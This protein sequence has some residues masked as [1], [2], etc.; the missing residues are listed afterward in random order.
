MLLQTLLSIVALFL[1]LILLVMGNNLLGTVIAL[2][3]E[4]EGYRAG[5]AGTVLAFFSIGFVLGSLLG[6]HVIRRVGHIRAFAV[7]GA[8]AG[9]AALL[10]SIHISVIGWGGLRLVLGFCIA[11]LMLITES[12]ANTRATTET[13]GKLLATYMVLF[14]LAASLGQFLIGWGDPATHH[15]FI[16]AAILIV[17]SLIPLSLTRSPAPELE[18][19]ERLGILELWRKSALGVAGALFSAIALSAFAAIG[20]IFAVRSGL[21]VGQV[22]AFMGL[23]ILAAML[24]Q[25]PIGLLSDYVPRRILILVVIGGSIAAG[26]VAAW[27]GDQSIL[28]LY[29]SVSLFYGLVACIYPLCLAL[30]HDMLVHHQIVPASATML[31]SA[32]LG[33]VIGPILGGFSVTWLGPPGLFFLT[34]AALSLL[35]LLG[36][37]SSLRERDP[38]VEE[39]THCVGVAPVTTTVILELDPRQEDFEAYQDS[40]PDPLAAE[41]AADAP[42]DAPADAAAEAAVEAVANPAESDDRK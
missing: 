2:R 1:S 16:V 30:T 15:L 17:V 24:L 32:G 23:A 13:R 18:A 6:I 20:P 26:L 38:A 22:A 28:W 12:W 33:S 11:G 3:M 7:F 8:V 27:L 29:L 21:D 10:H 34:A 14:Y 31:F 39:Q 41:T 5:I 9:A 36:I 19:G 37:Y 42:A 25:W 40:E 35:L 4:L